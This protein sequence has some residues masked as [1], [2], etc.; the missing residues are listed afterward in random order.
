MKQPYPTTKRL[1]LCGTDGTC[2]SDGNCNFDGEY[3][4]KDG[5]VARFNL[6]PSYALSERVLD[7]ETIPLAGV[8]VSA[9]GIYSTTTDGGGGY[10]LT[11]PAGEYTLVASAAGCVFT[12]TGR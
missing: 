6:A 12:P 8:H 3:Y 10:T 11:V 9:G 7:D 4:I 1:A 2:G 5:F